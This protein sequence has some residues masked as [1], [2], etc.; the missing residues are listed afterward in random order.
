MSGRMSDNSHSGYISKVGCVRRSGAKPM[1]KQSPIYKPVI[2]KP[3]LRPGTFHWDEHYLTNLPGIDAQ[4]H[5]LVDIINKLGNL[6]FSGKINIKDID[7]LYQQLKHYTEQHFQYE[8]KLMVDAGIDPRHLHLH[9]QVHH[10]FLANAT[11]IHADVAAGNL[12][13]ARSL[14]SFLTYWLAYHILGMD[15]DMAKQVRAIQAG[16]QAADAFERL[17]HLRAAETEPLLEALDG[18]FREV[19][20]QNQRLKELNANLEKQV[21]LRTKQLSKANQALEELSQTDSLT[22][23]PNR[24]HA[25]RLLAQFWEGD[26]AGH[27]RPGA[28]EPPDLVVMM[29]DAD[30]FKE[31]NDRHGHDAGDRVLVE[32]A[33]TLCDA[34]RNDDVVCRLGGDELLVIC[35][36]TDLLGGLQS[37]EAVLR[38]VRTL[39]VTTGAGSWQG[40]ISIGVAARTAEMVAPQELLKRADQGLYNAKQAGR[41]CIHAI[42]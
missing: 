18:L 27:R 32:L 19:T 13:R 26:G 41:N 2:H 15:Q 20:E 31:V 25:M 11:S 23:L 22:G 3:V 39:Q 34:M 12:K 4:H 28:T 37:A 17:E 24:R 1:A 10:E 42:R 29:I 5:G 40:S 36:H 9:Q 6:L 14:L 21:A 35:P 38:A 8:E 33:R 16:M 30:H 7:D